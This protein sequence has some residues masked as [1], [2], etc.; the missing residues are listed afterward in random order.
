MVPIRLGPGDSITPA[1]VATRPTADGTSLFHL[2]RSFSNTSAKHSAPCFQPSME[3]ES[4]VLRFCV[5]TSISADARDGILLSVV[6]DYSRL[7]FLIYYGSIQAIAPTHPSTSLNSPLCLRR[8]VDLRQVRQTSVSVAGRK[9][10]DSRK[11]TVNAK[12]GIQLP[13]RVDSP[14]S[15]SIHCRKE[16]QK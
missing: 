15:V 5:Q 16:V 12:E 8:Y 2:Q 7:Q 3:R 11:T 13:S 9:C 6:V 14:A 10:V 1:S 4:V